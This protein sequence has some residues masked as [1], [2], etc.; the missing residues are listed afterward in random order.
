MGFL[1]LL[2]RRRSDTHL[3]R[4][5]SGSFTLDPGGR[6]VASTLPRS[7][8][9]E[10]VEQIG[11]LVLSTFRSAHEAQLPLTELIA[12]YAALR[13]TARALRGGAIIFL[14]PR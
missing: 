1:N 6:I 4:L 5:P 10:H 11:A 7:F 12:D 3:T 2:S 9:S 13:L 8:P 14:A